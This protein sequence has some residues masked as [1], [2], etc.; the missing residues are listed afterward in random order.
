ME[1]VH[2]KDIRFGAKTEVRSGILFIN[3]QE[4]VEAIADPFFSS[5]DIDLARPGESVRIIPVKDVVE[6]RV[7]LDGKGAGSSFP[8]FAGAYEGCGEGRLKVFKGCAIV[9]TGTIVGVQEG[10][11]DMKGTCADYCYYSKL[12]NIVVVGNCPD[13]TEPHAH[14]AAC[15]LLGLHA[16]NYVAEA[17]M[18]ADADAYETYQ[19]TPVDPARKLPKAGVIYMAMAQGLIHDNYIYGL[20]R[21]N[22]PCLH[23][24]K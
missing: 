4:M 12:N 10:V 14:E 1:I 20:M 15:R 17:A 22:K 2:I 13:G 7:K 21:K 24:S 18:D 5:I 16:A 3:K 9:T 11:I 6:P 23:E 8:G 19:L